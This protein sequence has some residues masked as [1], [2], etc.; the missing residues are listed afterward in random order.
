MGGW[1]SWI[2]PPNHPRGESVPGGVNY[3]FKKSARRRREKNFTPSF[4]I[5]TPPV[6]GWM[7]GRFSTFF[8]SQMLIFQVFIVISTQK[9]IFFMI[10]S[11]FKSNKTT[12]V[13]I[14]LKKKF[15]PPSLFSPPQSPLHPPSHPSPPQV[16]FLWGGWRFFAWGG[17]IF[18]WG[19]GGD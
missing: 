3:Y 14:F 5:F 2:H 18:K 19:G 13:H 7:G 4:K 1:I 12:Q 16:T 17:E 10:S 11:N 6:G 15:T 8:S 9:V